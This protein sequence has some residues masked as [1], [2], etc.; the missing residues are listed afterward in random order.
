MTPRQFYEAVKTMRKHQKNW[1]KLHRGEDL[2]QSRVYE[3]M[4]DREIERVEGVLE[5]QA[6]NAQGT[7]EFEQ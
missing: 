3:T 6:R 1:F 4:I 5:E 2:T 7:L